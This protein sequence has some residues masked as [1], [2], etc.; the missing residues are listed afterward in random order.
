MKNENDIRLMNNIVRNLGST[1][2]EDRD[3]KR[4]TFFTKTLKLAEEI[5]NKTF[6]EL[7]LVGQG[8]QKIYFTF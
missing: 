4:K 8:I 6:D 5:H 2:A 1:G 7:N 3:S